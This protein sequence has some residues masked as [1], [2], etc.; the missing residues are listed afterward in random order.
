MELLGLT[1]YTRYEELL[2]QNSLPKVF[3]NVSQGMFM[4]VPGRKREMDELRAVLAP[5]SGGDP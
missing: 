5:C 2:Y 4:G 3:A 1:R